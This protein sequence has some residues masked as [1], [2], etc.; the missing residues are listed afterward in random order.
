[1]LSLTNFFEVVEMNLWVKYD[2]NDINIFDDIKYHII[3]VILKLLT[4]L[5]VY[6]E[7]VMITLD[8]RANDII[9]DVE[10]SNKLGFFFF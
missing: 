7:I 8:M 9:N 4:H 2:V 3:Y 10:K 6:C 5:Y 1:V